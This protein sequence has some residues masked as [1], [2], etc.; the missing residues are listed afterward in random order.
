MIIDNST[1]G[2]ES[3]IND[4][5]IKLSDTKEFV[6]FID[7]GHQFLIKQIKDGRPIYGITTGYGEAGSNY[8]AF[9]EA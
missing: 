4:E 5:E 8:A 1:L 6:K 2:Y 3:F 9:E 7:E